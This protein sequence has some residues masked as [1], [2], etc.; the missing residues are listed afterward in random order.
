M[1]IAGEWVSGDDGISRP[2]VNA[3]VPGGVGHPVGVRFLV[4]TGADRTVLSE[5]ILRELKLPMVEPTGEFSL[6]GLGGESPF[7]LV[8]ATLE[9]IQADGRA[10]KIHGDFAAATDPAALDLSVLG[11][12]VL[13]HFDVILGRH[14]GA[15][16]MLGGAHRYQIQGPGRP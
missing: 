14:R 12:D 3:R 9:L 5:A 1:V 2:I 15:I 7:V 13:D 16:V 8:K 10:A 4:D 11:R 6:M